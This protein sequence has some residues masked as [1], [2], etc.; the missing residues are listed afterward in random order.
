M[1]DSK[2]K[3]LEIDKY[4]FQLAN[5]LSDENIKFITSVHWS[6]SSSHL[7]SVE[8]VDQ[9][10]YLEYINF[11]ELFEGKQYLIKHIKEIKKQIK[12]SKEQNDKPFN[13]VYGTDAKMIKCIKNDDTKMN[14]PCIP[15]ACFYHQFK[16]VPLYYA[17]NNFNG[18]KKIAEYNH[19]VQ[20]II[21]KDELESQTISNYI[22]S[23]V[24]NGE[25]IFLDKGL[26][27]I[28]G[29]R[30]G[31]KSYLYNSIK[32]YIQKE[33]GKYDKEANKNDYINKR[34]T[35]NFKINFKESEYSIEDI[36]VYDQNS[37]SNLYKKKYWLWCR[38]Y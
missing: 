32:Y 28:V 31:G 4:F 6:K 34:Y 19:R 22:T 12:S 20:P 9:K 37:L 38:C 30:G 8:K 25:T 27:V 33:I 23:I 14:D 24:I 3:R 2:D 35:E 1:W 16:K 11:F 15:N 10:K 26:N 36:N 21:N 29:R 18:L 13:T 5:K 17:E 7:S